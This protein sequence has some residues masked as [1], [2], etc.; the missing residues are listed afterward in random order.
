MTAWAW[1]AAALVF[2]VVGPLGF[3][4]A[5]RAKV[6]RVQRGVIWILALALGVAA[7]L[8]LTYKLDKRTT[9]YEFP[10][11][12]AFFQYDEK[13]VWADFVGPLTGPFMFGNAVINTGVALY[14][15]STVG[16]LL[17]RRTGPRIGKPAK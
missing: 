4:K 12:A 8:I 15:L 7:G 13:G 5:V 2:L 9:V 14:V 16:P 6:S 17:T 3:W 11:P 1:L 10:L